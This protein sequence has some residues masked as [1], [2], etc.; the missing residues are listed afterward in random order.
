MQTW[1]VGKAEAVL[2][3]EKKLGFSLPGFPF[4]AGKLGMSSFFP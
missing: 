3:F 1:G 4:L 2:A